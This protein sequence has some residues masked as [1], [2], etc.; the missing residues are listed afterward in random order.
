L[1]ISLKDAFEME[2]EFSSLKV[3]AT[4]DGFSAFMDGF[5]LFISLAR[6]FNNENAVGKEN[7]DDGNLVLEGFTPKISVPIFEVLEKSN[8]EKYRP[9]KIVIL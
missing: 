1:K 3:L 5:S 9:K 7:F 6:W 4:M 8:R 2:I